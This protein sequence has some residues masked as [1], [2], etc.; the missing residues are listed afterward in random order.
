[1]LIT[2]YLFF[3][4]T[5]LLAIGAAMLGAPRDRSE[6]IALVLAW[7]AGFTLALAQFFRCPYARSV[8]RLLY[9]R[10]AT[11]ARHDIPG[12]GHRQARARSE[13]KPRTP[14]E[15]RE[16]FAVSKQDDDAASAGIAPD[17]ARRS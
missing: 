11:R 14:P 7:G 9:K 2:P 6:T 16:R 5:T 15:H 4:D 17:Q 3:Y 12:P 1:M 10:C 13:Q 8:V